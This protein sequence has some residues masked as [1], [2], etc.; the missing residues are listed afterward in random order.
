[1]ERS[2]GSNSRHLPEPSASSTTSVRTIDPAIHERLLRDYGRLKIRLNGLEKEN[3]GL[4]ASLWE[5]SWRWGRAGG[6]G[7]GRSREATEEDA[8]PAT[9]LDTAPLSLTTVP[10]SGVTTPTEVTPTT[11]TNKTSGSTSPFLV[12][13]LGT[14]FM[15]LNEPPAAKRATTLLPS[16]PASIAASLFPSRAIPHPNTSPSSTSSRAAPALRDASLKRD[17]DISLPHARHNR[18]E[19][20][21]SWKWGRGY[22]L[23]GHRAGVYDLEF[24]EGDLGGRGR[25]LASAGFDGIRLWGPKVGDN[26]ENEPGNRDRDE[27]GDAWDDGDVEEVSL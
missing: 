12:G 7:K 3:E 21:T 24:S 26:G 8:P 13:N 9:T 2:E 25:L 23:K 27:E 10:T 6:K 18:A 11:S 22:D 5:V 1:M 19:A 4:R 20:R 17:L 14:T 16:T 15:V